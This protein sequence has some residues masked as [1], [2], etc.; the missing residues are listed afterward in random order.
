ME[1]I[2]N[3]INK[4]ETFESWNISYSYIKLFEILLDDISESSTPNPGIDT[5]STAEVDN[6]GKLIFINIKSKETII[7]KGF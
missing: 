4:T 5:E 2:M 6:K 3:H 1:L 7:S